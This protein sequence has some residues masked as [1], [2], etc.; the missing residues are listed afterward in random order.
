M[1][2]TEICLWQSMLILWQASTPQINQSMETLHYN[3]VLLHKKVTNCAS[4]FLWKV[5]HCYFCVTFSYLGLAVCI[6][7]QK[8][9]FWGANVKALSHQKSKYE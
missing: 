6:F 5:K 3:I 8:V 2:S 1:G 7:K 9:I 4:Y